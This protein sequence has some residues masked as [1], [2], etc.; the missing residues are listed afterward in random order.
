[1]AFNQTR[2]G[3][4]F[5]SLRSISKLKLI[6][7]RLI[8]IQ[9]PHLGLCSLKIRFFQMSQLKV[10]THFSLLNVYYIPLPPLRHLI[11]LVISS[12]QQ[13]YYIKHY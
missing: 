9:F 6:T 3:P 10:C 8:L 11:T 12:E 1:M 13:N 4:Y 2:S 5:D 7:L